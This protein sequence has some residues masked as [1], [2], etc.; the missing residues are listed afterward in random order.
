[1]NKLSKQPEVILEVAGEGGGY[2]IAGE[3]RQGQWQ[4]WRTAGGSDSWL[5]DEDDNAPSTAPVMPSPEP[6]CNHYQTLDEALEQINSGWPQLYPLQVHPDFSKDI[7]S[8]VTQY[9]QVHQPTETYQ[10]I[11]EKWSEICFGMDITNTSLSPEFHTDKLQFENFAM[12]NNYGSQPAIARARLVKIFLAD[13][14]PEGIRSAQIDISTTYAIA[15]KGEQL[16]FGVKAAYADWI[17][18]SGIYLIIGNDPDGCKKIYVG[19]GDD[20]GR[21]LNF[22]KGKDV[23][24]FWT[25]TL[26]FVSKDDNLTKSHIRYVEAELIKDLQ[27]KSGLVLANGKNPPSNGKLPKEEIP[28]MC[29]FIDEIKILTGALGFNVF[30]VDKLPVSAGNSSQADAELTEYPEFTFN[31]NGFAAQAVFMAGGTGNW[32]VRSGSIARLECAPATPKSAVKI[33]EQLKTDGKLKE[34]SNGLLFTEDYPFPSSSAAAC[35]VAG[36]S[37]SGPSSWKINNKTYLQW[38]NELSVESESESSDLLTGL[39]SSQ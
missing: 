36:S 17:K 4:F 33:R 1:M 16:N 28:S 22:H 11:L 30:K 27:G 23:F 35:V 31:G 3:L 13:G 15:F 32:L 5:L 14:V 20:V 21:R 2:T 26:V 34:T 7:W 12:N 8:R 24:P 29:R 10:H 6:T 37:V 19:E 39:D 25:D 9:W 38:D 18:K